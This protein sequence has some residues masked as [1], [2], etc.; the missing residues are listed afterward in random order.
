MMRK[1]WSGSLEETPY[2]EN[3][4]ELQVSKDLLPD[5]REGLFM[6]IYDS[7]LG[8]ISTARKM[9]R[10]EV[11]RVK[12]LTSSENKVNVERAQWGTGT[13]YLDEDSAW[14]MV[15]LPKPL[16]DEADVTE[17]GARAE[18]GFDST[19]AFQNMADDLGFVNIPYSDPPFEIDSVVSTR[20]T[21]FKA[22]HGQ[23]AIKLRQPIRKNTPG[24]VLNHPQSG[25]DRGIHIDGNA[26][27]RSC[28]RISADVVLRM[29]HAK[30]LRLTAILWHIPLPLR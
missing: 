22:K 29:Y 17:Y 4:T 7:N 3:E 27:G 8:D 25:V 16:S 13:I 5:L 23:A 10:L 12:D 14:N 28:I 9:N 26:S 2:H 6:A 24:I 21:I 19:G 20:S 11:V 1:V 15:Q 18:V 30:M